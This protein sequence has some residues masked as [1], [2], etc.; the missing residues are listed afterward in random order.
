MAT[1]KFTVIADPRG[2]VGGMTFSRNAG[3]AYMRARVTP[4]NPNTPNQQIVRS[5]MSTLSARWVETLTEVQRIAWA[6]YAENVLLPNKHGDMINVGAIGMYIRSN[7]PRVQVGVGDLPIVDDAP[8]IFDLG[9]V[10]PLG[11]TS[12]TASSSIANITFTDSDAWVDEDASALIVYDGLSQ[13]PSINYFKGPYNQADIV[14]GDSVTP[15]DTPA[16]ID[17]V[18][19]PAIG[20]K[21]FLRMRVSR[22]DGRLSADF[23]D[24]G[25]GI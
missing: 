12:I 4:T 15:P 5:A 1:T 18:N 16:L 13:N 8:T 24:F 20:N 7:V 19:V 22:A 14:A 3:G 21:T 9:E 17:L 2:S 25:I 6:A 10:G 11:I 23:R